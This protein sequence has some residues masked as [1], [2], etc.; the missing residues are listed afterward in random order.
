MDVASIAGA[1]QGLKVVKELLTAAFEAKVDAEAKPKILEAQSRLGE[2]QDT[3]FG[4]R[5]QLF[6][7]QEERGQLQSQ[8]TAAQGW[9]ERF[10]RYELANTPGGAIVFRFKGEPAHFACPSCVNKQEI[11]VLQDN[12]TFSGKYRCTGCESEYPV[13]LRKDPS[14]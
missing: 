10:G 1:Y 14:V 5:E 12:R 8:L 6:Q 3:L 9:N 11:H 7:L 2:I 13:Q 4:L